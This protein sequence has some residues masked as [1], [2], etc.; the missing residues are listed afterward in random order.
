MSV[1]FSNLMQ[2]SQLKSNL[3]QPTI[4][5]IEIDPIG[6]KIQAFYALEDLKLSLDF[7]VIFVEVKGFKGFNLKGCSCPFL[8]DGV[9]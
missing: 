7:Y 8:C 5:L 2:N 1:G 6:K 4:I 9:V 3:S